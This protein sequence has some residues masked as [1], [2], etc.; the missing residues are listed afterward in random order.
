MQRR[1]KI[2]VKPNQQLRLG[3]LIALLIFLVSSSLLWLFFN[4]TFNLIN[5][6][7]PGAKTPLLLSVREELIRLGK[8]ELVLLIFSAL[9]LGIGCGV[10]FSHAIFGPLHRLEKILKEWDGEKPIEE[11]KFR[12]TDLVHFIAD[13]VNEILRKIHRKRKT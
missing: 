8:W 12:K 11:V 3:I 5:D 10:I 4:Y 2:L 6:I 1:R 13:A 7:I 9:T